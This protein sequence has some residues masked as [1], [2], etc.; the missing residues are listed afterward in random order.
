MGMWMMLRTEFGG[1]VRSIGYDL[2][3]RVSGRSDMAFPEYDAYMRRPRRALYG[4]GIA[5]LAAG[6]VAGTYFALAGGLGGLIL[7]DHGTHPVG[8]PDQATA[9]A[10][11]HA[12]APATTT[13]GPAVPPAGASPSPSGKAAH[14]ARVVPS[15][16]VPQPSPDPS[17]TKPKP[18]PSASTSPRPTKS[19]SPSPA[20]DP[21]VSPSGEPSDPQPSPSATSAGE[22]L[23]VPMPMGASVPRSTLRP[24]GA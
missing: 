23:N 7:G 1:A 11:A 13:T 12:P 22:L 21:S 9:T 14:K 3:Q 2:R 4:G 16:G 6:G 10:A 5:V 8:R 20:P 17:A 18:H 24:T 19:D 15:P